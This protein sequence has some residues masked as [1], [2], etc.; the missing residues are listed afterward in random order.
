M[1]KPAY[2]LSAL[3]A[4]LRV[5]HGIIPVFWRAGY[6]PVALDRNR[7]VVPNARS[8][9]SIIVG[10]PDQPRN[11][12][13]VWVWPKPWP[14]PWREQPLFRSLKLDD[15]RRHLR[16]RHLHDGLKGIWPK[17]PAD[18]DWPPEKDDTALA[19]L[20]WLTLLRKFK[21]ADSRVLLY[22][23]DAIRQDGQFPLGY[24]LTGNEFGYLARYEIERGTVVV[25]CKDDLVKVVV[26]G[27]E[28][29]FLLADPDIFD[30]IQSLLVS[31]FPRMGNIG[32]SGPT[33]A[34]RPSLSVPSVTTTGEAT[35][36]KLDLDAQDAETLTELAAKQKPVS[37]KGALSII[38]V[39]NH[40]ARQGQE[41][42]QSRQVYE[43]LAAV[44]QLDPWKGCTKPGACRAIGDILGGHLLRLDK[45]SKARGGARF[46]IPEGGITEEWLAGRKI[47]LAALVERKADE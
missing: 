47:D 18:G 3:D 23:A 14:H 43:A 37:R 32:D 20:S 33:A 6:A 45:G 38:R 5:V 19:S 42:V 2:Q 41:T 40:Y 28:Q 21:R 16:A 27:A 10:D 35:T 15:R 4:A 34:S 29:E 12:Q 26:P 22:V 9:R 30:G 11:E 1:Q 46:R 39:V 36:M 31:F 13:R 17:L 44:G 8:R 25:T 7:I 24:D